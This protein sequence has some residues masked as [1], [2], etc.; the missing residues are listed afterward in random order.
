MVQ[1]TERAKARARCVWWL[2]GQCHAGHDCRCVPLPA[3]ADQVP[4]PQVGAPAAAIPELEDEDNNTE[5][6]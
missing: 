5:E 2:S 3:P 4:T 6:D 1:V